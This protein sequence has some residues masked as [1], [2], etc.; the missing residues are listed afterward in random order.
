[1]AEYR[2]DTPIVLVGMMGSGKTAVGRALSTRLNRP[3]YDSDAIIEQQ[4][5]RTIS[6]FFAEE[7]EAAF[8]AQEATTVQDL[9][10]RAPAVLSLGGGALITP[11]VREAVKRQA[12][13]I[14]LN[15]SLSTLL[16][17]L[18]N[19]TRRPLLQQGDKAETLARLIQEREPYYAMADLTIDPDGA[20]I[21]GVADSIIAELEGALAHG[22]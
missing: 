18:A 20:T 13:S 11:E 16:K 12:F 4:T 8:R 10:G 19:D 21:E 22:R 17:R 1:M 5:G 3:F 2:L 15:A 7:G 9:L 6:S 14:W